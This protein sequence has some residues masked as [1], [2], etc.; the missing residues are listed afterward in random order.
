MV[1]MRKKTRENVG[2]S[3]VRIFEDISD[4]WRFSELQRACFCVWSEGMMM[5]WK[6]ESLNGC[7]L[8]C[9]LQ[10]IWKLIKDSGNYLWWMRKF[11]KV[12]QTHDKWIL[13][14]CWF[15]PSLLSSLSCCSTNVNFLTS[16]T[17]FSCS[18]CGRIN[19]QNEAS[20]F[21]SLAFAYLW[22]KKNAIFRQRRWNFCSPSIVQPR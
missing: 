15:S 13:W 7:Q 17:L 4:S 1:W 18:F 6:V 16:F 11:V 5:N 2:G 19:N 10:W 8:L 21:I 22:E 3:S 9:E 12:S 14:Y 20:N